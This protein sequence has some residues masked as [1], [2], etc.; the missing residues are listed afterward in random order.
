[1][2]DAAPRVGLRLPPFRKNTLAL[3]PVVFSAGFFLVPFEGPAGCPSF[4]EPPPALQAP[5]RCPLLAS[6]ARFLVSPHLL[7][8]RV[9]PSRNLCAVSL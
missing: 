7:V 5:A 6:G 8:A 4:T 2:P 9:V 1:M 3:S